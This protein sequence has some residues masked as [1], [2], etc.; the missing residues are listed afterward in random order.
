MN[1]E[2]YLLAYINKDIEGKPFDSLVQR[3]SRKL[4]FTKKYK[5]ILLIRGGHKVEKP[6]EAAYG[7]FLVS[8]FGAKELEHIFYTYLSD[9]IPTNYKECVGELFKVASKI[10]PEATINVDWSQIVTRHEAFLSR[11]SE[12]L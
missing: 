3:K 7:L 8:R 11:L 5:L 1:S 4:G 10:D 12:D 2:L 6:I 9:K